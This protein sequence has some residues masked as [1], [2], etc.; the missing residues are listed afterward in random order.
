MITT[1]MRLVATV[2]RRRGKFFVLVLFPWYP[3]SVPI[4][5]FSELKNQNK[6]K[7]LFSAANNQCLGLFISDN[8]KEEEKRGVVLLL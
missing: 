2:G 5:H 6:S 1:R 7:S 4:S 3:S 8:Y